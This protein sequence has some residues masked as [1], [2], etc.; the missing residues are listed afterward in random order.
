[1]RKI[2]RRISFIIIDLLVTLIRRIS[3][4]ITYCE[5]EDAHDRGYMRDYV[6]HCRKYIKRANNILEFDGIVTY[7]R[8][9]TKHVKFAAYS[10]HKDRWTESDYYF[11][12]MDAD[13]LPDEKFD[14]ILATGLLV[15]LIDVH[16]ALK[17]LREM[18]T[19]NGILILT[20]PG[21]VLSRGELIGFYSRFG[22]EQI[23]K[24]Y[25]T[26]VFNIREYG[27]LNH[28]IYALTGMGRIKEKE[29][30]TTKDNITIMTGICC[31]K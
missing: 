17:N 26:Q 8:Q 25:F 2:S 3:K 23:C 27:D 30:L 11:D 5:I 20:I 1:M 29:D 19:E 10:G 9:Y 22:A 6:Y 16:V 31:R 28:A 13:T 7:A 21:P 14:C 24:Q 12:V 18:L 4:S 15:Q